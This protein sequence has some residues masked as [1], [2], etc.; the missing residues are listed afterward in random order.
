VEQQAI[1]R[2]H[3]IGQTRHVFAYRLIVADTVEQRILELQTASA[4]W[5][6]RSW[7]R[8]VA[9]ALADA[10]RPG[11]AAVVEHNWADLRYSPSKSSKCHGMTFQPIDSREYEAAALMRQ[12]PP[13]WEHPHKRLVYDIACPPGC[14]HEGRIT[15]SRWAAMP[16][17]SELAGNAFDVIDVKA[18][19]YDYEPVGGASGAMEW[20]VNFA[21]PDLFVAYGSGLFAQDE[22]QVAEHP[23][24]G[25]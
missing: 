10:G 12:H 14:V 11:N 21:D 25:R 22:M 24:L 9:A 18:A 4:S 15:Y 6:M 16:L 8:G 5:R 2:A 1:D 19:I 17:A 20:H 3:R 23:A 13:R 7:R